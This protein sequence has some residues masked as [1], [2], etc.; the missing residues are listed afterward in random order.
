MTFLRNRVRPSTPRS[1]VKF[2]SRAES[3]TS[4]AADKRDVGV[5]HRHTDHGRRGVVRPDGKHGH[6]AEPR[7]RGGLAAH[8]ADLVAG[9]DEGR[10]QPGRHT[11]AA[12]ELEIP[13]AA[14]PEEPRRRGVR[15]LGDLGAREPEREQVGNEQGPVG[16]LDRPARR[17]LGRELIDGVE[18]QVLQAVSGVEL[19][20]RD[21]RVQR[22]GRPRVPLVAVV[23]RH[24]EHRAAPQ[25]RVVDGPRVDADRGDL[26]DLT[27]PGEHAAV[28]LDDVP[29]QSVGERDGPVREPRD[30]PHPHLALADLA[31]NHPARGRPEV[32]GGDPHGVRRH[33]ETA[34]R[35]NA[36]A[37]P[38]STGRCTPVVRESSGPVST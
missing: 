22:L 13:L 10:Q 24:P 36:A 34:Y 29:V 1:F 5:G 35:R 20:E 38:E 2:A 37:T 4:A 25:Q 14:E 11:D 12:R 28:E 33:H 17:D 27:E 31:E 26:V 30:L 9:V 8:D 19:G 6:P 7:G 18:R 3:V 23:E 15:A 16:D 21:A 32:D